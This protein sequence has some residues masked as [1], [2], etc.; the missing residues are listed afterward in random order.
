LPS[1]G[2]FDIS[3]TAG[4]STCHPLSEGSKIAG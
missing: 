1:T 4:N 2:A 3:G